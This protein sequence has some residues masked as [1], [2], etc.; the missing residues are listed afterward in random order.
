MKKNFSLLK[1]CELNN[2]ITVY[3]HTALK[4][5]KPALIIDPRDNFEALAYYVSFC[6]SEIDKTDIGKITYYD[7]FGCGFLDEYYCFRDRKHLIQTRFKQFQ[8]GIVPIKQ[9]KEARYLC[10]VLL[11]LSVQDVWCL[12]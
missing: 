7:E 12:K 8:E 5:D 1:E 4:F 10:E 11:A 2:N 6:E 3:K 9:T